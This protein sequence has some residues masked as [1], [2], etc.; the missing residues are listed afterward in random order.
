[1]DDNRDIHEI[2]SENQH[3]KVQTSVLEER[4]RIL[5]ESNKEFEEKLKKYTAPVRNKT[6]YKNHK[7]EI[8]AK[9]KAY[10]VSPEKKKEYARTAYLKKKEKL[11]NEKCME[12]NI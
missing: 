1:M 12:N 6:Y 10:Q 4:C 7:D 8:L 2:I 11:N 3:L 9:N 5:V